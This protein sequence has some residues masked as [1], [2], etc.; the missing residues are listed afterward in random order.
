MTDRRVRIVRFVVN[1]EAVVDDGADLTPLPVQPVPYA[2]A[3]ASLFN[4]DHIRDLLQR[5]VDA[6]ALPVEEPAS[7]ADPL[8]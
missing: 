3:D 1:I 8:S 7:R 6:A 5:Q 2:A 4:L